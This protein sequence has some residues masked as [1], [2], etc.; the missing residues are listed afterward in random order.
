MAEIIYFNG[1]KYESL[2]EMPSS[3]RR[4]YEKINRIFTD[5]NQDGLPDIF[6]PSGF[7]ELKDAFNTLKEFGQMGA[8]QGMTEEQISIVRETQ[9]G[10]FVN[11]KGFGSIHEMPSDIR[12]TYEEVVS[13]AQDGHTEIYEEEWREVDRDEYF[14][15]HDDEVLNP[16][17]TQQRP[18]VRPSIETVDSNNRF[19]L[20]VSTAILILG[21]L[22]MAWFMFF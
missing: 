12:K 5:E 8:N 10:I 22:A 15:P 7:S 13:S 4:K 19:I 18:L 16:Q 17:I 9:N 6:Q 20:L 21:L 2:A 3:E 1:R 11:G 14:K